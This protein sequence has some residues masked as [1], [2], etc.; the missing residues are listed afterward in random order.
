MRVC[1]A[2]FEP[3]VTCSNATTASGYHIELFRRAAEDLNIVNYEFHCLPFGEMMSDLLVGGE[4]CDMGVGGITITTQRLK[5][6]LHFSFPTY[7][8]SLGVLV[9]GQ[10]NE[11]STW[12][13][14]NPLHW[15]VWLAM[16]LTSLVIP[17]IVFIIESLSCHGFI[18]KQDW[19]RGLKQAIWDS[20][21]TLLNFGNFTVHSQEARIIVVG[22]G[23]LVL[24]L[25]NTYVANLAAFLTI[26]NIESSIKS[27]EDLSG[28]KI[29]AGGV[30]ETRLRTQ[31]IHVSR[32]FT[33]AQK[34]D[35]VE[36][37]KKPGSNYDALIYDEP[38][39]THLGAKDCTLFVLGDTLSP[40]DYGFVFPNGSKS[41]EEDFS[42]V[43]V[44]LQENGTMT[45]LEEA[46]VS[47]QLRDCPIDKEVSDTQ[48]VHFRHMVGLW[49]ILG[50]CVAMSL[51][52]I[53]MKWV[54]R[55]RKARHEDAN[56][57]LKRS[58][59]IVETAYHPHAVK[60]RELKTEKLGA[61]DSDPSFCIQHGFGQSFSEFQTSVNS[62]LRDLRDDMHMLLDRIDAA[63]SPNIPAMNSVA[64]K[65]GVV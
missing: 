59:T 1:T 23:F 19:S 49:I 58:K 4:K 48:A 53:F 40:F 34:D 35:E 17:V 29:V 64:G 54:K 18:H 5:A 11:G 8:G 6:G 38:W 12:S 14:L 3:L 65:D 7:R 52:G 10:V 36:L 32:T 50:V 21:V 47:I 22:Y 45:E 31:R 42:R 44:A 63:G 20:L 16:A 46:Y 57:G 55:V 24:I 41:I 62:Q 25:I 27:V 28:R 2:H 26:T 15:S 51:V 56:P 13:F 9:R 37:F 43:L 33:S 60:K 39:V 30:Y 61:S